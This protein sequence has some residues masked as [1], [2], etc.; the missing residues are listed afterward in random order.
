MHLFVLMCQIMRSFEI[1]TWSSS[2]SKA[3]TTFLP[4]G[5][6][7]DKYVH[8]MSPKLPCLRI[9]N[10]DSTSDFPSGFESEADCNPVVSGDSGSVFSLSWLAS[11]LLLRFK[12]WKPAKM[13]DSVLHVRPVVRVYVIYTVYMK[14]D[15]SNQDKAAISS[16]ALNTTHLSFMFCFKIWGSVKLATGKFLYYDETW[17]NFCDCLVLTFYCKQLG[18]ETL[19]WDLLCCKNRCIYINF[20][21]ALELIIL[22][23]IKHYL[24]N[25]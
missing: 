12:V 19:S 15:F 10:D 14:I 23:R 8:L 1:F 20:Q 3:V 5:E 11:F 4:N 6:R 16:S 24:L 17:E 2:A 9:L 22:K 13:S 18:R 7:L 25:W 21:H